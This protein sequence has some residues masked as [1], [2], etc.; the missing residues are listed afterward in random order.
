MTTDSSRGSSAAARGPVRPAERQLAPD[1][2]RGAMLLFIAL[3]NAPGLAPGGPA[4]SAL[5]QSAERVAN[6]LLSLFVHARAYPVFAIMFGYGLVQLARRQW[7]SS[8]RWA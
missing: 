7:P 4:Q 5:L 2:A 3:V 1:L 8:P 6:A